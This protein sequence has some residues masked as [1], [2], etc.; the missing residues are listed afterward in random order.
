MH[1][2]L[3]VI[4]FT[5][6]TGAGYGL[7]ALLGASAALGLLPPPDFALGLVSLGLALGLISS[8]LFASTAHLGH[9]ERAWRAF[10]QWRSSW[11]SREGV[12]SVATYV[13]AGPF[14]LLW[15]LER[16]AALTTAPARLPAAAIGTGT[17]FSTAMNYAPLEPI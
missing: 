6:A 15:G 1:P 9:P 7:L 12:A 10:S 14:G 11:L 13:P 2:A 5:T 3:S 16:R 8:G 4:F 17:L